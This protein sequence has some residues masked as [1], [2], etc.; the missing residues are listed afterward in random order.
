MLVGLNAKVVTSPSAYN[1]T[2]LTVAPSAHPKAILSSIMVNV[3]LVAQPEPTVT[4][5][6]GFVPIAPLLARPAQAPHTAPLATLLTITTKV[7]ASLPVPSAPIILQAALS[8]NYARTAAP[9]VT[10]VSQLRTALHASQAIFT[11]ALNAAV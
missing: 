10:I 2:D 4:I 8:L 11:A 7:P 9:D 6:L 1:V 5:V 3:T